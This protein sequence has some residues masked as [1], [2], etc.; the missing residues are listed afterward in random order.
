MFFWKKEQPTTSSIVTA[1]VLGGIVGAGATIYY[2]CTGPMS[3][4]SNAPP[5][6]PAPLS[7]VASLAHKC[8]IN[9]DKYKKVLDFRAELKTAQKE[10]EDKLQE[11]NIHIRNHPNPINEI[12]DA[13]NT[14]NRDLGAKYCQVYNKQQALKEA[15]EE[16][17]KAS[18]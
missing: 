2:A 12:L 6:A 17:D 18:V 11:L 15:Q 5:P 14:L 10:L 3:S 13:R 7:D 8:T 4:A 9:P 16:F 1:G